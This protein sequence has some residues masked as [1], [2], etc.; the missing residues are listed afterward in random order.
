MF[1][2][3]KLENRQK[4]NSKNQEIITYNLIF[5]KKKATM[6]QKAACYMIPFVWCSGI[7]NGMRERK[8][9]IDGQ[10]LG[11]ERDRLQK[12]M[13]ELSGNIEA[14]YISVGMIVI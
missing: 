13:E 14:F 2:S 9:I 1:F 7:S 8:Q 12:D 6:I 4:Q 10:G 5:Q 3:E 11:E